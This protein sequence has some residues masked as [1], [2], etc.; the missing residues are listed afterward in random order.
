MISLLLTI[1]FSRLFIEL[2]DLLN[3][4]PDYKSFS[5]KINWISERNDQLSK[6]INELKI[7]ESVRETINSNFQGF[8]DKIKEVIQ[9]ASTSLLNIVKKLPRLVTTLLISLIATFFISRDKELIMATIL[10]PFPV[11]W[12]RKIEQVE[13]DIMKAGV[14]FIRAQILLITITTIISI[15]GLSILG[16]SYS[17]VV[18]LSAGILDLIPVIGPS[19]I[20]IPWAIYNLI[21]GNMKFSIGLII[22]YVLMG[23]IRQILE[24]KIVGQSI[25]IHPLAILF[26]MYLGVQFFGVSGFFIGPASVVV[27][28]AIF[29]AGF[30]SIIVNE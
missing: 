12:Q 25:G 8:Y 2:N 9:N 4:L 1:S 27:L 23:A 14:G 13:E 30:I 11:K 29:Q 5:E 24:A 3:N 16:S 17:I 28:K 22:L 18:G 7:P 15:T 6:F 26:A 20:F 10:K 21:I 19:L